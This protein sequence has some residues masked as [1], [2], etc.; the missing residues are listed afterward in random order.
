MTYGSS[1]FFFWFQMAAASRMCF[2]GLKNECKTTS[3]S[4]ILRT[5][6]EARSTSWRAFQAVLYS[7]IPPIPDV[8]LC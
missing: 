5:S 1:G 4:E 8:K 6:F 7:G 2:R 3:L